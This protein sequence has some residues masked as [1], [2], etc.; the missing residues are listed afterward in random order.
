MG[1]INF[2]F[3]GLFSRSVTK[4]NWIKN[5]LPKFYHNNDDK[6][7]AFS[8]HFFLSDNSSIQQW[9]NGSNDYIKKNDLKK[10]I[11]YRNALEN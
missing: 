9:T 2:F 6:D 4:K 3:F 8:K 7:V 11:S 10:K 5:E 1:I